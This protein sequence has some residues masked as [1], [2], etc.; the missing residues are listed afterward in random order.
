MKIQVT[1]KPNARAAKVELLADGSYRVT[2]NAS[3]HEGKANAAVIE[4]LAKFFKVPKS[5]VR[6]AMG[7]KGKKKVIIIDQK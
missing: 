2:V 7:E 1:V 6:I 4:A 5:F 3:P